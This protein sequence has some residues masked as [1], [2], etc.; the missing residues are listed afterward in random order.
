MK[1]PR[2]TSR[3]SRHLVAFLLFAVATT[4]SA[5]EV[6]KQGPNGNGGSCPGVAVTADVEAVA[7]ATASKRQSSPARAKAPPAA[8]MLRSGSDD[9]SRPRWHSFLPGM[10]R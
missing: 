10:F 9:T 8:P 7:A 1:A 6:S 5:R 3:R 2:R 4:A